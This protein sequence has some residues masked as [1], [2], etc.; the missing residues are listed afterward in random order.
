MRV[1]GTPTRKKYDKL[2]AGTE[3]PLQYYWVERVIVAGTVPEESVSNTTCSDS[4]VFTAVIRQGVHNTI[5][6]ATV[7]DHN[8]LGFFMYG[9]YSWKLL[10]DEVPRDTATDRC[11]VNQHARG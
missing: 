9:M 5:L 7:F 2:T 6:T 11:S 1:P 10:D 8:R 3:H 4:H